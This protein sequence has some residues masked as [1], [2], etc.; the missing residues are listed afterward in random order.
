MA[1]NENNTAATELFINDNSFITA[2]KWEDGEMDRITTFGVEYTV[3]VSGAVSEMRTYL[4]LVNPQLPSG[5]FIK[6]AELVFDAYTVSNFADGKISMHNVTGTLADGTCTPAFDSTVLGYLSKK[7]STAGG[8]KLSVDITSIINQFKGG[9][10]TS[11]KLVFKTAGE[12]V[13]VSFSR[14]Y[15]AIS[16][17]T[18]YGFDESRSLHTHEL[19]RFGQGNID[20]ANGSL[21]FDCEDFAWAGNRMPVTVKHFYHSALANE[22]YTANA[23]LLNYVADYSAMKLGKGFRLNLMQSMIYLS[24]VKRYI[25]VDENGNETV[26]KSNYLTETV[27][28]VVYWKYKSENDDSVVYRTYTKSFIL[29]NKEYFF[30]DAGRLIRITD[31]EYTQNSI[32]YTYTD[33][34]LTSVTDGAGRAFVFTYNDASYLTSITAPDNSVINYAYDGDFLKLI[35]YPDGRRAEITYASNYPSSVLICDEQGFIVYK[36]AYEFANGRLTR[37]TEFGSEIEGF[38]QGVSAQYTYYDGLNKTSAAITE[39]MDESLGETADTVRNV[40]YAFDNNDVLI[41]EYAY[42]ADAQKTAVKGA[43]GINPYDAE[44]EVERNVHNL[45]ANHNFANGTDNWAKLVEYDAKLALSTSQKYGYGKSSL[46]IDATVDSCC[47]EGVYQECANLPAGDYTFSAYLT[48]EH[49]ENCD[50]QLTVHLRIMDSYGNILGTS[51]KLTGTVTEFTRLILPFTLPETRTVQA[52]VLINNMGTVILNAPQLE[53]NSFANRYNYIVNGN[54]ELGIEG[55]DGIANEHISTQHSFN[56][57][58]SLC[59][60][61]ATDKACGATQTIYVNDKASTLETFTLSAWAKGVNL[62]KGSNSNSA[63]NV[64][65]VVKYYYGADDEVYP[66][67]FSFGTDEWQHATITF[68]K[69]HAQRVKEIVV[70]CNYDYSTG[71]VYFDNVCLFRDSVQTGISEADLTSTEV[72]EDEAAATDNTADFEELFDAFGN[73]R[74]ET[75]FT[76]GEFGAKYRKFTYNDKNGTMTNAGNDLI[77]ETDTRR[78]VTQYIVDPLTSRNE[79]VIDRLGNKTAYEYD[80][81]GKT[82]KVTSLA[83]TKTAEGETAT[84][85][86]GNIQYTELANVSYAYDAFDNLKEITRG[87]GMKYS[88]KYNEFHKLQSIGIDG[89][90]DG[91]LVTYSYKKGSGRV[92]EVAYAD[93][94]K[95]QATYNGNGQMVAEIWSDRRGVAAHYKYVYDNN[96]N[97]VRSIDIT[98]KKEYNYIYENDKIVRAVEYDI[99]LDSENNITAKVVVNTIKYVYDEQDRV[100]KKTVISGENTVVYTTKYPENSEPVVTVSYGQVDGR[101]LRSQSK[102]DHLG[103]K[104]F[105]ELQT[106]YETYYRKYSYHNGKTNTI[107]GGKARSIATTDLVSRIEYPDGRTIE[108]EYDKEERITKVTDSVDGVTEYT[109]DALGQLLTET[110]NGTVINQMT[111]DNYG[112]ILTK[113]GIAYGYDS[114]WKDKLI[115]YNGGSITYDA[116]GGMIYNHNNDFFCFGK[117]RQ[118]DFMEKWHDNDLILYRFTYNANGIRTGRNCANV[119]HD[120]VLDGT[121]ILK[122]TWGN[123]VLIPLYDNEDSVC[124]AFYNDMTYYFEKNLQGDVIAVYDEFGYLAVRYSYDAWGKVTKTVINS[125]YTDF[126]DINPFLYRGYYYDWETGL[127]YL[128]SRYYDP[129][130]GRFINADEPEFAVF[131]QSV[132]GHNL[133]AYCGNNVVNESDE[134][135]MFSFNDLFKKISGFIKKLFQKFMDNLKKQIQITKKYIKI[136]VTVIKLVLDLAVTWVVNKFLK[137]GIEK[138][139]GFVMK[140]YI[141][142]S[143]KSFVQL[144]G[145]ILNHSA[146]KWLIKALMLRAV[147]L[148]YVHSTSNATKSVAVDTVL[149]VSKILSKINSICSACSSISGFIAFILDLAD[150]KWD[151][152]LTIKFA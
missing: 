84:D 81:D 115:S 122:E 25:Y 76:D 21:M 128:Q 36:V 69:Q 146:T 124:G 20:L 68:A 72:P 43:A 140:K 50:E 5:I 142:K 129:E 104:M 80:A 137:W 8:T 95:M 16:Y 79:A 23:D 27:D 42:G 111:Y 86:D 85:A 37:V 91:D 30:D 60:T 54:F 135:G 96:G 126:A 10:I 15:L 118:L 109:Y 75:T 121:K 61:G 70:S 113:N 143:T 132:L 83:E 130:L 105:D 12:E 125:P 13:N 56:M 35:T 17:E 131:E 93:G 138:V 19:G 119:Q 133:F 77:K 149:S 18:K 150:K 74:T 110:K 65:A 44:C 62:Q 107:S 32:N 144:L 78:N 127:Y 47:D 41:S 52:Q 1:E 11:K 39:P 7:E 64:K 46:Y 106:G 103:R 28:D 90:T 108:Y 40:M 102:N 58:K 57:S 53:N 14:P 152:Y 87:D 4:E 148:G 67:D 145:K 48:T 49:F 22:Q 73:A 24:N 151:D 3:Y 26:F 6:K 88:L 55:W 2:Y 94:Y 33:G 38:T 134:S 34:K 100:V 92:K 114:V 98:K 9:Q 66:A 59:F 101:V 112:N 31:T 99:T 45:L 139:I 82:T 147:N 51:E 120:Y 63:F 136:S 71:T 116:Q 123:N 29:D 89:K 141:Q 117:G 97:L